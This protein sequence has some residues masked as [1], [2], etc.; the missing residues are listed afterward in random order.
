[1]FDPAD[2]TFNEDDLLVITDMQI[3]FTT[4]AL[5]TKRAMSIIPGIAKLLSVFPGKKI[6]TKDTHDTD[7]L[8]TQEGKN[9]SVVHTIKGT[10]GHDIAPELCGLIGPYDT[11]I[12]KPGFGSLALAD[13]IRKGRFKRIFFVGVCTGICVLSNVV[14]AKAA[15]TE[16]IVYVIEDLCGCVSKE[17]HDT[18]LSAMKL[19][20][21][22]II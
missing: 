15:D 11:I 21:V 1:M 4:G 19:I 3:D 7:Y 16:A 13:F 2:Y 17:S 18:A 12:E 8:R 14:I 22:S 9:L 5:G 10:K 20:Q 6:W